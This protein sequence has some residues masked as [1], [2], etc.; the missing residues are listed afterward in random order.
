[1]DEKCGNNMAQSL[2]QDSDHKI[3]QNEGPQNKDVGA[4]NE[5]CNNG[6]VTL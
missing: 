3:K 6:V 5:L 1:M 4:S 2:P